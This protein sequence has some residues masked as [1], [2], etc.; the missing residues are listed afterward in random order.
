MQEAAETAVTKEAMGDAMP[1]MKPD[2]MTTG[3]TTD[4]VVRLDG[5]SLAM[6][7]KPMFVNASLVVPAQGCTVLMGPSGTGKSSLLRTLCG[8]LQTHPQ[9]RISGQIRVTGLSASGEP[10]ALVPVLVA[11]KAELLLASA[12]ESLVAHWPERSRHSRMAQTAYLAQYLTRLGQLDL[13]ALRDRPAIDLPLEA[14]RRIGIVGKSLAASSLLMIDE[15]TANLAEPDCEGVLALIRQLAQ[16][17]PVLVVTHNQRHARAMADRVILVASG[18]VQE[19]A[20]VRDFFEHPVSDSAKAFLR[21]GSCPEESLL[22][23][24]DSEDAGDLG[25][26]PQ[27]LDDAM[28]AEAATQP[29]ETGSPREGNCPMGVQHPAAPTPASDDFPPTEPMG[30]DARP[31]RAQGPVRGAL[32]AAPRGAGE[33]HA[34]ASGTHAERSPIW[35]S[36][37]LPVAPQP[38]ALRARGPRGFVWLLEGQLAGT[39]KPGLLADTQQ[40]L[41]ALR[42]AGISHLLSLTEVPFPPAEAQVCGISCSALPMPDMHAPSLADGL[43]LC[44][45]IDRLLHAGHAVAVHCKAGLGRTGTVLAMYAIWHSPI[46]CDGSKSITKVRSLNAGMIQSVAQEAFLAQFAREVAQVRQSRSHASAD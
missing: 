26:G 4:D 30:L 9:T 15:P 46:V 12:W 42:E 1:S 34:R 33:P 24:P 16:T 35:G 14:R 38:P 20:S 39:P 19:A 28:R 17:R 37:Q 7:S 31:A 25:D 11:Q 18:R 10:E 36:E 41:R 43:A 44:R 21:T 40:D 32:Q 45:W 5:F 8:Q 27:E 29:T 2:G 22:P 13:L 23:M 3:A 6:G